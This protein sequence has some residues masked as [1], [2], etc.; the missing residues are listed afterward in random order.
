MPFFTFN[1]NN[2]GGSFAYEEKSG[3]SHFVIVEADNAKKALAAAEEIGLYFDGYGDCRCCGDRWSDY[4][5][6]E[7]GTEEP[8]IYDQP[9]SDYFK[10]EFAS[11]WIDGFE[12][13]VHYED[14]RIEGHLKGK[15]K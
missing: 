6:D 13:F 8:T 7:D 1:Q 9:V 3:I 15:R 11:K 2:S 4:V 10:R 14:G 5:D 12:A